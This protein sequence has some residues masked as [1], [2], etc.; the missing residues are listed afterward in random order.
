MSKKKECPSCAM[1]VDR[2]A[3]KCHF[4]GYEFP[5]TSTGKKITAIV[6]ILLLL[7]WLVFGLLLR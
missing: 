6:L 5:E 7:V 2:G 4:C 1:E 3:K